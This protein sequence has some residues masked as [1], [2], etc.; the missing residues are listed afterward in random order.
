MKPTIEGFSVI[1]VPGGFYDV[2]TKYDLFSLGKPKPFGCR[3]KTQEE[4]EAHKD[5]C[6]AMALGEYERC[7]RQGCSFPYND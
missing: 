5:M 7:M 1:D 3:F 4:A 2:T 6:F